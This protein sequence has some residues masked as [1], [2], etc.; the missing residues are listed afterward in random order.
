MT[1]LQAIRGQVEIVTRD[2][3]QAAGIERVIYDNTLETPPQLPI[4]IITLSFR[5]MLAP[6][7]G[8]D[9]DHIRGTVIVEIRTG[10]AQGSVQGEEA[11][12]AVVQ[13]WAAANRDYAAALRLRFRDIEGPVTMAPSGLPYHVHMLN[14]GFV[15]RERG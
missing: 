4:A 7:L 1:Q 12:R 3:L 5:G 8:C 2:S 6:S 11:G 15:A 14:C 9:A 13:G 10:K